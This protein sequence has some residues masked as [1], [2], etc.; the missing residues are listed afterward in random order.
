LL[1]L[2]FC[3]YKLLLFEMRIAAW[4]ASDEWQRPLRCVVKQFSLDRSLD[5]SEALSLFDGETV[6]LAELDHPRIPRL[7]NAFERNGEFF[8]VWERIDGWTL[9]QEVANGVPFDETEVRE[10]LRELLPVLQ[11]L[12][13][14]W[15]S[16]LDIKPANIIRRA[17]DGR[18][19]LVGFGAARALGSPEYAAP[20]QI[21][22]HAVP[23]SDLYSSGLTCLYLLTRTSPFDLYDIVEDDGKWQAYLPSTVSCSL[24]AVLN[25]LLQ[26]TVRRRYRSAIEAV[27]DIENLPISEPDR[28][29]EPATDEISPLNLERLSISAVWQD[30]ATF[31]D[32]KSL[33]LHFAR[34]IFVSIGSATLGSI[35][36]GLFVYCVGSILFMIAPPVPAGVTPLPETPTM[37]K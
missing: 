8:T 25:K 31:P 7:L 27:R 35:L 6:R 37:P 30:L 18:L 28:A 32:D 11:Y 21:Q 26:P 5:L 23:A 24:E 33:S 4:L 3:L 29:T 10:L 19:M 12:H 15:V 20:E 22:G 13:D 34:Q 16:H 1:N 36:M 9:E 14:H 17:V 2:F